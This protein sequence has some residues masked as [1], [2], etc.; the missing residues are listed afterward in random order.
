MKNDFF[1]QT[2]VKMF[3]LMI[4]MLIALVVLTSCNDYS[5]VTNNNLGKL[6]KT[7]R[8]KVSDISETAPN[9]V[10]LDVYIKDGRLTN[11]HSKGVSNYRK[12]TSY[13]YEN[14]GQIRM[15]CHIN[16]SITQEVSYTSSLLLGKDGWP[17]GFTT[18]E[19]SDGRLIMGDLAFSLYPD[20]GGIQK[21]SILRSDY[22]G[23]VKNREAVIEFF[24]DD[25]ANTV[26][27]AQRWARWNPQLINDLTQCNGLGE[28]VATAMLKNEYAVRKIEVKYA[29]EDAISPGRIDI[30]YH[31]NK[32]RCTH[33]EPGSI[34]LG[35]SKN[36][37]NI[38]I[39]TYYLR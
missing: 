11:V 9:H 5:R 34:V 36:N 23:I 15:V 3:S 27:L 25:E 33:N 21:I 17:I 24:Y 13:D 12:T 7:I 14:E 30:E 6:N 1:P 31:D 10:N 35:G 4:T 22:Q 19:D 29:L 32:I 2:M 18:S 28:Y 20:H 26:P 16:G 39:L 8:L 38:R 37:W